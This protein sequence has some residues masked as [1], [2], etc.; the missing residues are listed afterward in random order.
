MEAL[1]FTILIFCSLS[2]LVGNILTILTLT[3]EIKRTLYQYLQVGI[4]Q[5]YLKMIFHMQISLC[6]ADILLG[7]C[8]PLNTAIITI[9]LFSGALEEQDFL[10]PDLFSKF[11][12]PREAK[13]VGFNNVLKTEMVI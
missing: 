5:E 10:N 9:F 6:L 2:T 8:G 12:N 11:Q 3:V 4:S 13:S 7:V 1:F